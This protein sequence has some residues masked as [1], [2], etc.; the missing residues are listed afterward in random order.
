MPARIRAALT[1][2][3]K[4]CDIFITHSLLFLICKLKN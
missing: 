2:I 4:S 3:A 1:S